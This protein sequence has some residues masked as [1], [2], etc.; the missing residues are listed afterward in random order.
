MT[1]YKKYFLPKNH[2]F[3]KML[4]RCIFYNFKT[5]KCEVYS[6]RFSRRLNKKKKPV[7]YELIIYFSKYF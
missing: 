4:D 6:I 3:K 2:F 7:N 5:K 1:R